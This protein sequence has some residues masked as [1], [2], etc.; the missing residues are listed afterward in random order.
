VLS[1]QITACIV[2]RGD[3]DL[4]PIFDSLIFDQIIVWDN[5]KRPDWKCAGRYF[6]ALEA[7]TDYVY[8]QDDDTIVP[9]ETQREL[10]DLFG[11]DLGLDN[12]IVANWGHGDNPDGYDD[13]PL[14]CGGAIA[15]PRAAWDGIASYGAHY[16]LDDAF[17]YEADFVVGALYH[18][19]THV[20]LPFEI[21]DVAYNGRRLADEPWQRD[22]K[23]KIT[24]RARALRPAQLVAEVA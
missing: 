7:E 4:Q 2:T 16:P 13:L 5:S 18:S 8:W 10:L 21:R 1:F 12:D 19:W 15:D 3:V 23:L 24:D 17:K 9:P 11:G 14:V 22:L 20:H 6:A